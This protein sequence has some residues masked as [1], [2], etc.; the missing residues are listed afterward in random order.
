MIVRLNLAACRLGDMLLM[1]VYGLRFD[2]FSILINVHV[3]SY[4]VFDQ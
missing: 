2:E 3:C 4:M 1:F